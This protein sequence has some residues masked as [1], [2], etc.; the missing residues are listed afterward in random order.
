MSFDQHRID[1]ELDHEAFLY[2]A[3]GEGH[4]GWGG[5]ATQPDSGTANAAPEPA[6]RMGALGRMWEG[7]RDVCYIIQDSKTF[8]HLTMAMILSNA[9]VLAITWWALRVYQWAAILVLND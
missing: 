5:E 3:K 8:Q 2:D 6:R 9:V 4:G 7:V 1:H